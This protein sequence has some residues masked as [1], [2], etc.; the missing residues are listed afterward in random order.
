MQA[1]SDAWRCPR[2]YGSGDITHPSHGYR[3]CQP[4]YLQGYVMM[5]EQSSEA[6]ISVPQENVQP[7]ATRRRGSK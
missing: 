6:V 5:M 1:K 2:C 4:C 3:I 7:P